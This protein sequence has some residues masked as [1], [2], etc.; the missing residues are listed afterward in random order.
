MRM[1]AAASDPNKDK[2]GYDCQCDYDF[3][4]DAF[5]SLNFRKRISR[6]SASFILPASMASFFRASKVPLRFASPMIPPLY[7]NLTGPAFVWLPWPHC[8]DTTPGR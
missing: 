2:S 1:P 5:S 8:P 3:F 6:L 4:H 7:K